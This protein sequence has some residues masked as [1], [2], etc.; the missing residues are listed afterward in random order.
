LAKYKLPSHIEFLEE[1]PKNTTGKILRRALKE[2]VL[3]S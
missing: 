3:Q 1:L 2:Q